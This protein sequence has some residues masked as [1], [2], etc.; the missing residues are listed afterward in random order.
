MHGAAPAG[1]SGGS[2]WQRRSAAQPT[3]VA[4]PGGHALETGHIL[5]SPACSP[6]ERLWGSSTSSPS[7]HMA[8]PGAPAGRAFSAHASPEPAD[9]IGIVR[10]SVCVSPGMA[11]VKSSDSVRNDSISGRSVVIAVEARGALAPSSSDG[12]QVGEQGMSTT[13]GGPASWWQKGTAAIARLPL[14]TWHTRD[15]QRRV[16]DGG[17]DPSPLTSRAGPAAGS[18]AEDAR[19]GDSASAEGVV[20]PVGLRICGTT[21]RASHQSNQVLLAA[22]RERRLP[23]QVW[24][25]VWT[26]H[27][28][29]NVRSVRSWLE[30]YE[31]TTRDG[32]ACYPAIFTVTLSFILVGIFLFMAGQYSAFLVTSATDATKRAQQ[33][34]ALKPGPLSLYDWLAFW[35]TML[36]ANPDTRCVAP[37]QC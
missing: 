28:Y 35:K 13:A 11:V 29:P 25:K 34:Q 2:L 15:G 32:Q 24:E 5:S 21:A 22:M 27:G 1:S 6:P 37:P 33:V 4:V 30:L 26:K 9:S 19:E 17:A 3:P 36:F 12:A 7:P 14:L 8:Q 10:S 16:A 20:Q 23:E 18:A 31:W